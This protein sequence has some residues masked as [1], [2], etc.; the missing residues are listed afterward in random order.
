[1]ARDM[2]SL[3]GEAIAQ[4]GFVQIPNYLVMLNQF[5]PEVDRLTP[6]QLLVIYQLVAAWW[7][8]DKLP[9]PAMRTIATRIGVSERQ[10]M[11]SIDE[12]EKK[13][14]IQRV[15]RQATGVRVS[16]AYDLSGLIDRM[17]RIDREYRNAFPRSIF[18]SGTSVP[19]SST[20]A[21]SEALNQTRPNSTEQPKRGERPGT[22]TS[23]KRPSLKVRKINLRTK[24]SSQS[25]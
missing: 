22:E 14:L 21:Q 17:T 18:S 23:S 8:K 11:R 20:Q 5:L 4:R 12:L 7:E 2:A 24:K 10:V 6:V 25:E 9:F 16:N 3:W 19:K 1:M 13:N 15:K